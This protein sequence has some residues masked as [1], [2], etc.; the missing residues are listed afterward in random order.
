MQSASSKEPTWCSSTL[1]WPRRFQILRRST[2]LFGWSSSSPRSQDS[3]KRSPPDRNDGHRVEPD[4]YLFASPDSRFAELAPHPLLARLPRFLDRP[5]LPHTGNVLHGMKPVGELRQGTGQPEVV[6]V[7]W[8]ARLGSGH[9]GDRAKFAN[10]HQSSKSLNSSLI[11]AASNLSCG[12]TVSRFIRYN[13]RGVA[14]EI[15][16]PSAVVKISDSMSG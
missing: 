11:T 3:I 4:P 12:R 6:R 16:V 5:V 1:K 15:R 14:T 13:M 7:E 9:V 2:T 8:G 10:R